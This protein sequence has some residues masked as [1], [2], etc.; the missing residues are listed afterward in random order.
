MPS[1]LI[2]GYQGRLLTAGLTPDA[3]RGQK[4][5]IVPDFFV[6]VPR[7]AAADLTGANSGFWVFTVPRPAIFIGLQAIWATAG[8]AGNLARVKK[9]L[10][11]ATSA[12]GAAAN[13]NNIDISEN[14]ALDASINV[15]RDYVPVTA[16][17]VNKLAAG[18]KVA[19]ASAAGVTVLAGADFILQFAWD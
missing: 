17:Y 6:H 19:I 12:P 3:L 5:R 9:V 1:S 10:A 13:A 18:D 11:A 7:I 15:R 16:G 4:F 8:A 2:E 14:I